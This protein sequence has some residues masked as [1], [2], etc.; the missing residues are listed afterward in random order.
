[1]PLLNWKTN[2]WK[3]LVKTRINK[4]VDISVSGIYRSIYEKKF[5]ITGF[6]FMKAIETSLFKTILYTVAYPIKHL[7]KI[8][9]NDF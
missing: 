8:L 4:I 3:S 5:Q 1:M 7:I 9:K 6:F 2:S